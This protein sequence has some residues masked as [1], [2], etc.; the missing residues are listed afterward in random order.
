MTDLA[1]FDT[2]R[3]ASAVV[4][5]LLIYRTAAGFGRFLFRRKELHREYDLLR[6]SLTLVGLLILLF[7]LLGWIFR[8]TIRAMPLAEIHTRDALYGFSVMCGTFLLIV[9][10]VYESDCR[11][12]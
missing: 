10:R 8:A 7:N 2:L 6:L 9:V 4:W 3:V 11:D 12:C 1:I 5:A